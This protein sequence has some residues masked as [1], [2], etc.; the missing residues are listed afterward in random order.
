MSV[1]MSGA[2]LST[3]ATPFNPGINVFNAAVTNIYNSAGSNNIYNND[4]PTTPT[5]LIDFGADTPTGALHAGDTQPALIY[6]AT[7]DILNIE[8]G[9][10]IATTASTPQQLIAAKPFDIYAGRDIVDSGTIASPDTFLNLSPTDI[11]SITAGRDIIESSFNIAGPGN[12]VVQAGRNIYL[13]DQGT[14][15]SIGLVFDI[16]PSDRNSGAGVSVLAGVGTA[17]PDYTGFADLFLNPASAL[18]MCIR[19]RASILTSRCPR[20]ISAIRR[21]LAPPRRP[22]CC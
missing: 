11:T 22:A 4:S 18:E 10:F 1:S 19:D 16:N 14:I 9:Q 13:A 20:S 21:R 5:T 15:N 2:A 8:F 3:V 17:G 12:L 7:G 6:A